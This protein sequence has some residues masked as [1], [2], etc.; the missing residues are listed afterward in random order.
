MIN[1]QNTPDWKLLTQNNM[2]QNNSK[3]FEFLTIR[4]PGEGNRRP[5]FKLLPIYQLVASF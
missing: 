5:Y 4:K 2:H 1:T 3:H